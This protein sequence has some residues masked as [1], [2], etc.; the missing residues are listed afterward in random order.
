[1]SNNT[2]KTVSLW[3]RYHVTGRRLRLLRKTYYLIFTSTINN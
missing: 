3:R 2:P 1:M